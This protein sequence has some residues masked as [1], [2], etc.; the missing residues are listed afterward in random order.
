MERSEALEVGTNALLRG[1]RSRGEWAPELRGKVA[2]VTGAGRLRSIGRMI[3]AEL[4]RN[5][6]NVV[7][8]GTGRDRSRFTE[9]ELAVDWNDVESVASEAAQYGVEALPVTLDI[10]NG[11]Q[12]DALVRSTL[13]HFG[14]ID[15]LINNAAASRGGDRAPVITT[16]PE[17]WKRVID[18]N[19]Y[20]TF[21]MS[22]AIAKEFVRANR[23]GRIINIS[24]IAS[25]MAYFAGSSAYT[26]SKAAIDVFS[27]CL[28]LELG[29]NDITVN[30]VNPGFI[31]TTRQEGA[32]SDAEK[33]KELVPLGRISDGSDI[34]YF[35][36]YLCSDM[37][38]WITG[39][40][41]NIDGGTAWR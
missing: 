33:F 18:I 38:A 6:V 19:L 9:D 2:I 17:D 24:S 37:G 5:G 31:A 27:R 26:A 11:D 35:V 32:N 40:T 16:A 30:A 14:Q 41:I 12:V 23:G 21:L 7:V 20:G 22:R 34:A 1:L 3:A 28:A 4:A 15:I 13:E 36:T 25:K 8:T 39:Q 29:G 10:A